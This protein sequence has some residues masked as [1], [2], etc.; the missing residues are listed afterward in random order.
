M[1]RKKQ[2]EPEPSGCGALLK[3]IFIGL[4]LV[5]AHTHGRLTEN[6]RALKAAQDAASVVNTSIMESRLVRCAEGTKDA[7][8]KAAQF[9]AET[10]AEE[11]GKL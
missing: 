5:A 3:L 7:V 4:L 2:P 9:I 6:R 8:R 10:L 11:D 1:P